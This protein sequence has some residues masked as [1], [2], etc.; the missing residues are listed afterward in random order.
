MAAHD[1]FKNL[2]N[3]T[4]TN[5]QMKLLLGVKKQVNWTNDEISL[6]SP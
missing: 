5:N 3:S 4:F 6:F 2:L 1:K